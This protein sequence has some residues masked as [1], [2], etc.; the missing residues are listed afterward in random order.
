VLKLGPQPLCYWE[1]A[2]PSG[3]GPSERS[4]GRCP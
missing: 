3:G 1:A 4:L 2:G